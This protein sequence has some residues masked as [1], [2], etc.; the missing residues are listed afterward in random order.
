MTLPVSTPSLPLF[1]QNTLFFTM[2]YDTLY[3]GEFIAGDV[4][5][6]LQYDNNIRKSF[7]SQSGMSH[8]SAVL[9]YTHIMC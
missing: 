6:M 9:M 3:V 5:E 4:V 8:S 2:Y 7:N 1:S